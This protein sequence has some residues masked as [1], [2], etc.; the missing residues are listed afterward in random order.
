MSLCHYPLI[1]RLKQLSCL[2]CL[3]KKLANVVHDHV[4]FCRQG[5]KPWKCKVVYPSWSTSQSTNA[6]VIDTLLGYLWSATENCSTPTINHIADSSG[7]DVN[8]FM[9]FLALRKKNLLFKRG[10]INAMVSSYEGSL[11]KVLKVL[12]ALT[13]LQTK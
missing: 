1:T 11:A 13:F 12:I 9:K 10:G 7:S 3:G 6:R 5:I 2:K 8:F 4:A